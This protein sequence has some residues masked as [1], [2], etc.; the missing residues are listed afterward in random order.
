MSHR[1]WGYIEDWDQYFHG[2]AEAVARK[3]KDP[4]CRVGAAIVSQD[5]IVLATGF[6]GLAR[7]VFDDE[8]LLADIGEKLKWICHAEVNAIFNA[9][10]SGV[11]LKGSTIFVTKF[12]C[13]PCCNAIAQ[14]GLQRIYTLDNR[15]WDEDPFDGKGLIDLTIVSPH[16]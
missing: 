16:C 8:S 6:N 13:F 2:I 15:Y 4:R 3:S 1:T 14:A 10:R 5:K 7:G 11:S 12:P 9:V